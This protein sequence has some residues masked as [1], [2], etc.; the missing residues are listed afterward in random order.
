MSFDYD[1]I[2]VKK[3]SS[4]TQWASY[5]DLFMVLA[6]IFLLMYMVASLR[7]GMVS[8]STH[9][10]IEKVREELEI[11]QSVKTQYLE[12]KSNLQEKRVYDEILDQIYLLE[13][14]SNEN[15]NRLAKE[16]NQQKVRES[17]LNQ[18]QQMIVAM[19]DANAV[20]KAEAAK[21]FTT[22]QQQKEKLA[23]EL[24]QKSNDLA[25]IEQKL[26][27]ESAEK[28]ALKSTLVEETQSLGGKIQELIGQRGESEAQLASLQEQLESKTVEK[29][30]LETTLS[31]ETQNLEGKI[32]E[33]RNQ[34][35][36]S[37]NQLAS[38]EQELKKET[39][40]KAA[41]KV[42]FGLVS[43]FDREPASTR[44]I[45]RTGPE[46]EELRTVS[47]EIVR[48]SCS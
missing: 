40:E 22:E 28:A 25:T 35:S 12:E 46:G 18:F 19:I 20:A 27:L 24:D 5:S 13:T 15:Q 6:F 23:K 41:S 26:E 33:L 42:S 3:Q 34:Q 31:Q 14:E 47:G 44:P 4:G 16:L 37:Q 38:L 30:Q 36:E 39:S 29:K 45:T 43:D 21:Q 32:E 10:E 8:I 11:I 1:A 48:T 7:T 2:R 9:V 17:E